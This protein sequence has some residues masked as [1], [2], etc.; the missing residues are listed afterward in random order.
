MFDHVSYI[1]TTKSENIPSNHQAFMVDGRVPD[2]IPN[3]F[4]HCWN[5]HRPDGPMTQIDDMPFP[6]D[7]IPLI[8]RYAKD[9]EQLIKNGNQ[10]IIKKV[11]QVIVTTQVDADACC[12]AAWI[13]LSGKILKESRTKE[14]DI[15]TSDILRAIAYD[16]DH[17]YVPDELSHLDDFA[18][19]AVATMTQN[20]FDLAA[21][22]GLPKDRKL[23]TDSQRL[24]HYSLSFKIGTQ[25]LIDAALGKSPWPGEL[26]EAEEYLK[27]VEDDK[28]FL[29]EDKRITVLNNIAVCDMRGIGRPIDV[30]SFIRAVNEYI[31]PNHNLRTQMLIVRDH[32]TSGH[33][34]TL[35]SNP[36]H[37]DYLKLDYTAGTLARLTQAEKTKATSHD[38]DF[39]W[40]G[41]HQVAG[42]A[43][44]SPSSLEPEEVIAL[45]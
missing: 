3:D 20:S 5:H 26:G 27:Q 9:A 32:G 15:P 7:E 19:H 24:E 13:Q 36:N 21:N 34:Y 39:K 44:N 42:S 33:R 37:P 35:S 18:A 22:S 38:I 4:D 45:L 23:W 14:G 25:S 8:D 43:W 10:K 12:A 16:C 29:Y 6:D 40:G 28:N 41:R 1:A 11:P 17:L 2:W 31:V 30:R